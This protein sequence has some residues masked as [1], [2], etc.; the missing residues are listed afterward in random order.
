[1]LEANIANPL[2]K[3]AGID[4]N[5]LACLSARAN[6][7]INLL[8]W[9]K[10]T[11]LPIYCADVLTNPPDIGTFD[12]IVGNPPWVNW[13]TLPENYR[14]QT[15]SLWEQYGLF[16]HSGFE[17]ILG[18]GK[19]DLSLVLTYA[20]ID[21]YLSDKGKLAFILPQAILKAG[22]AAEGFRQ[23]DFGEKAI[24]P[25]HVDDFSK[26]RI[27][28]GAETKPIVLILS[29][30]A[31][32]KPSYYLWQGK[33]RTIRENAKNSIIERLSYSEF[34][35]EPVDD[36]GSAWLTGKPAALKAVR[37]IIGQSD[38][39]AHAGVYTGGANAVYWLN[40][41]ER[42]GDMLRVRNIVTGSKRK[43]EQ[44]E[45]WLEA[46]LVYPMLRG[47][48]VSRWNADPTIHILI[49]QNPETRQGY[50]IDWLREH[51]PNTYNYLGKFEPILRKRAAFKRYFRDSAPFYTM[52]DIGQYTFNPYKVLWHGFGKQRMQ[53][54]VVGS[55][56][57]K[58]IMS[59]QAMHP[60]VGLQNENE[61][62]FL[63]ACLNSAPFEFAVLSHT[64]SG[65]K[66]FAQPGILNTLRLPQ[67][68][69]K[70]PVH[71]QLVTL[72]RAAHQGKIDDKA[73]AEASADI[74]GLSPSELQELQE[75]LLNLIN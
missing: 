63:A 52:F 56:D 36:R 69:A 47:R 44:I 27:F 19:K 25:S 14:Q 50:D 18:K 74:W 30:D 33:K 62:H 40:V 32:E 48:D 9:D 35:A 21:R 2:N 66:S 58:P 67:Y 8:E 3:I 64:Q 68:Q 49:V 54:A 55:I 39:T 34:V 41:L 75:S 57:D 43:V 15:K 17:S 70:N 16:P 6:L 1:M 4:I 38:Y 12:R 23:F 51:Y 22:G 46:D 24:K 7:V 73:I 53:A 71:Q 65:G 28:S 20:V 59:N 29:H 5:P 42:D 31:P 13:E 10:N 61:A 45:T 72:S 60:F 37:K 11:V 26:L